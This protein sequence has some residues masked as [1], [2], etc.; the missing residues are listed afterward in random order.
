MQ[1]KKKKTLNKIQH[2][3]MIKELNKLEIENYILK[4]IKGTCE[5]HTAI[6][7]LNSES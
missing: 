7:T 5:K 1:K 4:L 3:F 2:L 6:I